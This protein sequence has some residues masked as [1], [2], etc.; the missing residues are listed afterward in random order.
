MTSNTATRRHE[1]VKA[2]IQAVLDNHNHCATSDV[3][4][5]EVDAPVW[6]IRKCVGLLGHITIA[7]SR[8]YGNATVWDHRHVPEEHRPPE[9]AWLVEVFQKTG[10]D[11]LQS[12][13]LT[14]LAVASGFSKAGLDRAYIRLGCRA[15]MINGKWHRLAPGNSG[16]AVEADKPLTVDEVVAALAADEV[17]GEVADK[18]SEASEWIDR[19][20]LQCTWVVEETLVN[21]EEEEEVGV[22]ESERGAAVFMLESRARQSGRPATDN[23]AKAIE[24]LAVVGYLECVDEGDEG[25]ADTARYRV[26]DAGLEWVGK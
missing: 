6:Q 12:S 22:P 20:R 11:T 2:D 10:A 4:Y 19:H 14:T 1:A 9:D 7:S 21:I 3:L 17:E 5:R 24:L 23:V 13:R 25:E 16:P 15:K 18:K 8:M 26:T